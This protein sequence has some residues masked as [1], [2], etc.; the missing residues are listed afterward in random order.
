MREGGRTRPRL[1]L[2]HESPDVVAPELDPDQRAVV[3]H[4]GSPLLVLAGPGTGKTT[5]IVESVIARLTGDSALAPERVL[6][7]TFSRVAAAELRSRIVARSQAGISPVVATFHSFAWRLLLEFAAETEDDPSLGLLAAPDSELVVRELLADPADTWLRHWPADRRAALS[8]PGMVDELLG[9]MAAAR[10]HGWE[11]QNLAL[12]ARSAESPPGGPVPPEWLAAAAFF[13]HYLDVLDWRGALDYAE[14]IHRAR[15]LVAD[16]PELAGRFQAIYVDEYQDTDPAQVGLIK[17][18]TVPGTTLVAVGDPDQAIYRFRGADVGGILDFP[19]QFADAA[20]RPAPVAVLRRTRRFGPAIRAVADRWI[21]PVGLGGLPPAVQRSHR[22][23]RCL[24]PAGEVEVISCTSREQQAAELADLLRRSHLSASQPLAWSDM[25]VL[26]RSG[27]N[28]IPR[29]E[30]ALLAAGVPVE[31]P[32]GDRPLAAEPAIAP[33]L[34]ALRLAD[35]PD[36]VELDELEGFLCAPLIG[37]T[38]L[39]LRRLLRQLRVAERQ[40]AEAEARQPRSAGRLLATCFDPQAGDPAGITGALADELIAVLDMIDRMRMAGASVADRL[41]VAWTHGATGD[42][43]G[44]WARQLQTTSLAGGPGAHRADAVLDAVIEL[45][46]VARRMPVGAG[47][48]VFVDTLTR[49]RLPAAWLEGSSRRRDSVSLLTVHRAKGAQWPMVVVVGLQQDEWP[50]ARGPVSILTSERIGAG[51]V[52]PARTRTELVA[53]ERRLAFVAA[54]RASQRL[55]IMSV[56][57]AATDQAPSVLFAEAAQVVGGATEINGPVALS[58]RTRLTPAALVASLRATLADPSAPEELRAAAAARLAYVARPTPTG[59][60]IAR[61]AHPDRWWGLAATS[62]SEHA[63]TPPDEPVRLSAT[64]VEAVNRC[65]LRWFLARRV[66]AGRVRP[67]RAAYGSL[68]HGAVAA[69]ANGELPAEATAIAEAIRPVF[70]HLPFAADWERERAWS[71][72]QGDIARF[73]QWYGELPGPVLGAEVPFDITSVAAAEG[74][75]SQDGDQPD[76]ATPTIRLTGSIDLLVAD[77]DGRVRVVD[78]KTGGVVPTAADMAHNVQLGVY[79]RAV[80]EGALEPTNQ[81]SEDTSSVSADVPG[82]PADP[83]GGSLVFLGQGTGKGGTAPAERHQAPLADGGWLDVELATAAE[84]LT[85]ERIVARVSSACDRC[86]FRGLCP[87]FGGVD[88]G[89][90]R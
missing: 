62:E 70:D 8:S 14:V 82:V 75:H 25:A 35:D 67:A 26:V 88:P 32:A 84:T 79:Q 86:D 53:D 5:T 45:F 55:V 50:D 87:A 13:D 58:G 31:V 83:G 37:M 1:R 69:V 46:S 43:E 85:T 23:P 66:Q 65:P 73:L 10:A 77:Q 44:R 61:D 47:S 76:D 11:P 9:L 17:D 29:L 49:H 19:Q 12:A 34:T 72:A 30:R 24:G 59:P 16:H 68:L 74:D 80:G 51:G 6:V 48:S 71:Q 7:L 20:Q 4:L 21:E 28:D 57:S 78:F 38:P 54:T 41:W 56:D 36:G 64:A 81:P 90:S 52:R 63:L 27:V 42:G 33:L 2:R 22:D 3:D 60:A 15:L 89:A 40:A 39:T 18:L